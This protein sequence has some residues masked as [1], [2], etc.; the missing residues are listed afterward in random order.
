MIS[1]KYV[2]NIKKN[3]FNSSVRYDIGLIL[4]IVDFLILAL[5]LENSRAIYFLFIK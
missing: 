4:E 5:P 1:N 3:I 2:L